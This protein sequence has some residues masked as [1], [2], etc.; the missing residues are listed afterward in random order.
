MSRVTVCFVAAL[1]AG[2]ALPA[3]GQGSGAPPTVNPLGLRAGESAWTT[4]AFVGGQGFNPDRARLPDLGFR[5]PAAGIPG[6]GPVA[7]APFGQTAL[8]AYTGRPIDPSSTTQAGAYID[9]RRDKLTV[10]SGVRQGIG[11]GAGG[12]RLDLGATYG[13]NVTPRHLISLSGGLTVGQLAPALPYYAAYGT[14]AFWRSG[15]RAGEP[16]LGLRLSWFYSFDRST[17]YIATTLGFDRAYGDAEGL[18]GLERNTTSVG[19][20]FGYRW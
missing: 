1:C 13:F 2:T 15:Y 7:A 8:P 10:S 12:T 20:T 3:A 11:A 6:P 4:R 14:D 9:Y 19:T 16:G 18:Q 17:A 5:L